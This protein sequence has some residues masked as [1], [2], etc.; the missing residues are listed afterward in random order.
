M[1]REELFAAIGT[2]EESRLERTEFF[3]PAK[4]TG[5]KTGKTGRIFRDFLIAAIIVSMLAVTAYAVAGYLIFESPEAM[6]TA[7]FG[8]KTGFDHKGVTTWTDPEKPGS[9]YENPGFDRVPVDE[10]VAETE[11]APMVNP[12]G[13]SIS[14]NGYTLRVDANLYDQVT[15]CGVLTYTLENPEGLGYTVDNDGSVWFPNGE[16]VGFGQ[17]GYSYIIQDQ[18]N[19]TKLT[20]TYYY[21]LRDPQST[22]LKIGFTEWASRTMEEQ[23]QRIEE[24]KQELRREVT[25]EEALAYRKKSVG[26]SWPWFEENR[27]REENIES[28]YEDLAYQRLEAPDMCPDKIIIPEQ[29][30]G[31]MSS[32]TLKDG[33]ITISPIAMYIDVTDWTDYPEH[34]AE[35]CILRFADGTEYVVRD[36]T[37]ENYMFAVGNGERN[38]VNYMFNRIVDVNEITSVVLDGGIEIPVT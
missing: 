15:K 2:V 10:A 37:H 20:A 17:Y 33:D 34:E 1:T 11:V 25:E 18:S 27:T 6:I 22:N 14:W 21:Q 24:I 12:V 19:D 31:E 9:V 30:L 4:D 35:I 32:I 13:Q 16:L 26:D 38:D 7:I 8:D 5:T 36:E 23:E 28:A 3:V 29:A